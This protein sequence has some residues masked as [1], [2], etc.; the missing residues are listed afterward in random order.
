MMI[1]FNLNNFNRPS[2]QFKKELGIL[3]GIT[4]FTFLFIIFFQPFPLDHFDFDNRLLFIAGFGGIVFLVMIL[5][6]T[7]LAG[8]IKKYS[9]NDHET[10][11]SGGIHGFLIWILSAIAFAFYLQYVGKVNITF[12][13]MFRVIIICLIPPVFLKI[14]D[15]LN[16]LSNQNKL[17]LKEREKLKGRI[18]LIEDS[19]AKKTITFHSEYGAEKITSA[20]SDVIMIKSADNYVEIFLKEDD[21]KMNKK[22]IRNTLKNIEHQLKQYADFIRCH[23]TVIINI[24]YAEK[25]FR[26]NNNYWLSVKDFPE[27]VPVSRQYLMYV[28][29][30]INTKR[31]K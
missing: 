17:L 15:D 24:F 27:Q 3:A 28:K 11:L 12:Y 10:A 5:I 21:I 30:A 9:K 22:L 19:T 8:L 7:I 23:R 2:R 13:I 31:G 14:Y 1:H 4:L 6:R 20:V 16:I 25:L 29:E 26:K 18:A